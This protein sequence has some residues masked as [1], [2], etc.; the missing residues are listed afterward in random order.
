MRSRN[1]RKV[2]LIVVSVVALIA[3]GAAVAG[4]MTSSRVSAT[5]NA[6]QV[7]PQKPKGHVAQASGTLVGT[8]AGSGS[9]WKLAWRLAYGKLDDPRIVIADVHYGKPGHFGPV[10]F[11]LCGPCRSGQRGVKRVPF[12]WVPAIQRGNTFVTLITG[13]NPNGEVRGQIR[14]G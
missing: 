6:R 3:A 13:K 4:K 5:M 1:N 2:V 10:V 12:T 8:L 7:I 11:R 9:H 14:V